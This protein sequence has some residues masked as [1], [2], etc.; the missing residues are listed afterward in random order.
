MPADRSPSPYRWRRRAAVTPRLA[1]YGAA[2]GAAV[3]G[4]LIAY[5]LNAEKPSP[6]A[7]VDLMATAPKPPAAAAPPPAA[8]PLATPVP[9]AAQQP[10]WLK[11]ANDQTPSV[12]LAELQELRDSLAASSD[13]GDALTQLTEQMLLADGTRRFLQLRSSA[14]PDL[15]ELHGLVDLIGPVLDAQLKR[16]E[17]TRSDAIE[18]K[19]QLLQVQYPQA[20]MQQSELTR[21]LAAQTTR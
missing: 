3:V 21:W 14:K 12:T 19:A 13:P 4:V 15:E 6:A 20:S 17:L 7:A 11:P 9:S 2:V 5:T 8:A 10:A 1:L 16:G 18:L